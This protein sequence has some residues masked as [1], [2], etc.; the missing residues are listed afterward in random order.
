MILAFKDVKVRSSFVIVIFENKKKGGHMRTSKNNKFWRIPVAREGKDIYLTLLINYCENNLTTTHLI[1]VS[2]AQNSG[3]WCFS[4]LISI[5]F[6]IVL[7]WNWMNYRSWKDEVAVSFCK[8]DWWQKLAWTKIPV[9]ITS[10]LVRGR[11][12][13]SSLIPTVNYLKIYT[14]LTYIFGISWFNQNMVC[15]KFKRSIFNL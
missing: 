7:I 5:S 12:C 3:K 4:S 8:K 2:G 10:Q 9:I 11:K 1:N 14:F 15:H 13:Y 6:S